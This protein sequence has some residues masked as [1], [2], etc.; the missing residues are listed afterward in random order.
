MLGEVFD[1]E[2]YNVFGLTVQAGASDGVARAVSVVVGVALLAAVWRYQSFALAVGAALVLSPISWLDY[3][4][5]AALPLAIVRPRLSA[6]W[7]LPLVTWGLRGRR[8]GYR[9]RA[10]R[11]LRLLLVFAVVLGVAFQGERSAREAHAGDRMTTTMRRALEL[12]ALAV[13]PLAALV[14]GL[15]TFADQDRLALD[16]HEEV[17]PQAEAIVHGTD[18]YPDPDS[19]ITD[20]TNAIW[21]I[22]AVLPAVPLTAVSP[23]AADW[24]AT[25]VVLACLV[26]RLVAARRSRLADL[27]RD[28]P[29]AVGDRRVPDRQRDSAADAAARDHVAVSGPP[30][31]R[32]RSRS[33]GRWR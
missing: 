17:Y 30:R 6:I 2:S 23:A 10:R 13:V 18:P 3:Y 7:F 32:R 33:E 29:L 5:L 21:P 19:A 11:P 1:H 22:A 31:V 15:A 16:F 25:F 4:A 14:I 20:T 28:P 26:R 24:I 8:D 9:R 12:V 27:R